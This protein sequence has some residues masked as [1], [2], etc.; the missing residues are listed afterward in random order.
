MEDT[1][2]QLTITG[3]CNTV[4]AGV[5]LVIDAPGVN[6]GANGSLQQTINSNAALITTNAS[7]DASGGTGAPNSSTAGPSGDTTTD[8]NGNVIFQ[9]IINSDGTTDVWTYH[10]VGQPFASSER[11]Y[12][13]SGDVTS[14]TLFDAQ[15]NVLLSGVGTLNSDGTTTVTL[16]N[17]NGVVGGQEVDQQKSYS[18]SGG[19]TVLT[20]YQAGGQAYPQS[21]YNYDAFDDLLSAT[22]YDASGNVLKTETSSYVYGTNEYDYKFFNTSSQLIEEIIPGITGEAYVTTDTVYDPASGNALAVTRYDATGAVYQ[23]GVYSYDNGATTLTLDNAGGTLSEIDVTNTD[24]SETVSIFNVTGE[25]YVS[26][27]TDYNTWGEITSQ[28]LYFGD[29]NVYQTTTL[30]TDYSTTILTYN[31]AGAL[32]TKEID[33]GTR[34]VTT[35]GIVGQSYNTE[36]ILYDYDNNIISETYSNNDGTSEVKTFIVPNSGE[37]SWTDSIYNSA[38]ALLSQTT[39]NASGAV[40]QTETVTLNADGSST[41]IFEDG[42]GNLTQKEIVAADGSTDVTIYSPAGQSTL[43]TE[44]FYDPNGNLDEQIVVNADG[45]KVVSQYYIQDQLYSTEI[46]NYNPAGQLPSQTFLDLDGNIVA[47]ANAT[48]NSDGSTTTQVFNAFG[49][50]TSQTI[51][52][53]NGDQDTTNYGFAGVTDVTSTVDLNAASGLTTEVDYNSDGSVSQTIAT[54]ANAD[55]SMIVSDYDGYG[56]LT[57]VTTTESDGSSVVISYDPQSASYTKSVANYDSSGNLVSENFYNADGS[58]FGTETVTQNSDGST[59]TTNLDGLGNVTSLE[60]QNADGSGSLATYGIIGETYS[61][62]LIVYSAGGYENSET[63]FNTDGT[64]EVFTVLSNSAYAESDALYAANGAL[65]SENLLD[66]NGNVVLSGVPIVNADGSVTI[67]FTDANGVLQLSQTN[68]TNGSYETT[69]YNV[70]GEA[71]V[72]TT[73]AYDANGDLLSN[74]NLNSDGSVYDRITYTTNS[75]GSVTTETYNGAGAVIETLVQNTDGSSSDQKFSASGTLLESLI[76]NADGSSTDTLYN[77]AGV[78]TE[79]KTVNAD[80]SSDVA[81]YNITSQNYTATDSQYDPNGVLLSEKITNVDGSTDVLTFGFTGRDYAETDVRFNA[82]G[83]PVEKTLLNANGAVLLSG[84]VIAGASAGAYDVSYLNTN[85]TVAQTEMDSAGSAT[86]ETIYGITGQPYQYETVT[87]NASGKETGSTLYYSNG[88]VY[89]YEYVE[90][91][92]SGGTFTSVYDGNYNI[93]DQIQINTGESSEVYTYPSSGSYVELDKYYNTS[94]Q[95]T[96]SVQTN[97]N[98]SQIITTYMIADE[99]YV[100]TVGDY[101]ID[102]QLTTEN[103]LNAD[104]SLYESGVATYNATTGAQTITFDDPSGNLAG[105]AT[106]YADGSQD[107]QTFEVTGE[108]YASTDTKYNS[109]GSIVSQIFYDST[110]AVFGST[111]YSYDDSGNLSG[112]ATYGADGSIAQ[113][114]QIS[115]GTTTTYDYNTAG[116]LTSE[117]VLNP[118]GSSST[119]Q[120]GIVGQSYTSEE[121]DYA[122]GGALVGQTFFYANGGSDVWSYGITG[123]AFTQTDTTYAANGDELGEVFYTASGGVYQSITYTY[124]ADGSFDAI[125]T[126]ANGSVLE[127]DV[128]N[129][130]GSSVD[131]F[132]DYVGLPYASSVSQFDVNGNLTKEV[133]YTSGGAVYETENVTTDSQ[134]DQTATVVDANGDTVSV[135]QDTAAGST[136]TYFNAD[137]S[138]AAIA[139]SFGVINAVSGD[140]ITMYG[141]GAGETYI[142]ASA[143]GDDEI[144]DS[145][146]SSV[147]QFTN[148]TSKEV[149]LSA[150]DGSNLIITIETA[151]KTLT[152][153]G[154]FAGVGNGQIASITFADNV[155]LTANQIASLIQ[156]STDPGPTAANGTLTIGHGQSENITNVLDG[157]VTPG[158]PGDTE[159]LTAVSTTSGAATLSNGVAT[160]VAPASGLSTISYTETD[161]LG[162]RAMGTVAVTVD[163]GPTVTAGTLTIGHGENENITSLLTGL[164]TPG[165]SGDVETLTTVSATAGAATLSNGVVTFIAPASGSS[166]VS[167]AVTDELGDTA[168]GTVAVSVDPG[169]TAKAGSLTINYGQSETITSLLWSLVTPGLT[170]DLLSLTSVSATSGTISLAYGEATF[171]APTS[172][173]AAITFTFVDQYGDQ[174]SGQIAVTTQTPKLAVAQ[175]L[176]LVGATYPVDIVDSAAN[177][178]ASLNGLNAD[179][180]VTSIALTDLT[181]PSLALTAAQALANSKALGEITTPYTLVIA[182]A[183]AQIQALTP[184]QIATLAAEKTVEIETSDVAPSLTVA[185]KAAL[186][187]AAIVLQQPYAA[188]S[189]ENVTFNADG[190]LKEIDCYGVTGQPFTRFDLV[191]GASNRLASETL[192]NGATLYETE[193]WGADGSYDQRVY[194]AGT[195]WGLSYA[196][197]ENGYA[198]SG[199]RDLQ[200]WYDASGSLLGSETLQANGA[201]S[202]TLN[203]ALYQVKTVNADGSYDI[204]AYAAGSAWGES[205]AS[206]DNAY[207]AAGALSAQSWSDASGNVLASK[208]LGANGGYTLMLNGALS[209]VKTVD[210]DGAYQLDNYGITGQPY[211][212]DEIVYRSSGVVAALAADNSA[213]A[214]RLTLYGANDAV[215]VGPAQLSVAVGADIFTVNPHATEVIAASASSGDTFVFAPASG[216]NQTA[217]QDTLSGF[218]ATGASADTLQFSAAAFGAG[219]TAANQTADW[220]A[221]LGHTT[222]NAAGSAVI[223]DIYGDTLTFAGVNKAALSANSGDIRFV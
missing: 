199:V 24:G 179:A 2:G 162:D 193:S 106:T 115:G 200:A 86:S 49:F 112:E 55:G 214:G 147:I 168:T 92:T 8:A 44:S 87:Y 156:P 141:T 70:T 75:A 62:T 138:I 90:Q 32:V 170:G 178:L 34:D 171:T 80:G 142:Y 143:D 68:N 105:I 189:F 71:Y 122:A 84:S 78:L 116:A 209:Q 101:T 16:Y 154:Q 109:Q 173:T 29:G 88:S 206:Y 58:I 104:G 194:A 21:V 19:P 222:Q 176:A 163:P 14:T 124:N 111:R 81:L 43:S 211:T 182:D 186:G 195:A 201:Y 36:E 52:Y 172:G 93:I 103:L 15:G 107:I 220:Q 22:Y 132:F 151:G 5:D 219:L 4:P 128:T 197:Y 159:T 167:Y 181:T 218:V 210:A 76:V 203:G 40:T 166:T 204:R 47:T 131:S 7:S 13:A 117:S 73:A 25:P 26:G 6:G 127:T 207:T 169:P 191:Y 83:Q 1:E 158:L 12:D 28:T 135:E 94:G 89:R 3:T 161:Q 139:Q 126:D 39:Y 119:T 177:V 100:E 10:D 113:L 130:D 98:Y 50:I 41:E 205:Y 74:T 160:F 91:T 221:L 99:P 30:N 217:W 46:S 17:A 45:S 82:S 118:D 133:F 102:G 155:T 187:A 152:I 136:V 23:T 11:V 140:N 192:L 72:T 198:A 9:S 64:K 96:E 121:S 149:K 56:D 67:N 134:G 153:I 157:L 165:L 215:S 174:A 108:P 65:I 63:Y 145:G 146:S 69:T 183:A 57:Q 42:S 150:P 185:Q 48:Q 144:I 18:G 190:T 125:T 196:S 148:I 66:G 114:V 61:S 59:T 202:L 38:G 184:G 216:P 129:A 85:G 97:N 31:D 77:A 33:D 137:G 208:S 180:Q 51:S 54:Q 212:S 27:V 20:I 53:A 35:Y 188:G 123:L 120:F 79:V 223:A 110:G 37:T 175:A 213:G 95:L 164:V 60:I